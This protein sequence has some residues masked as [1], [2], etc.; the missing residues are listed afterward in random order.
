VRTA[1]AFLTRLPVPAPAEPSLD[2]A[3][4]FFPL[5]GLLVGGIAAGV[6]ALGDQ[7][8][9]PLPSTLLAIAAALL[10]TGALHEDGL[11]DVADGLGAHVSRER[12]LE[13]LRDPRVGTFGSLALLVAVGLVLTTVGAL[14]TEHAARAL[15]AAHVLSRWAMLPVSRFVP[16]ARPGGAGALLRVKTP[17]LIA[18]TV[19]AAVI[20]VAAGAA[21][22]LPAAAIASAASAAALLRGLGGVTGDGY[23]ATAKLTEV[24]VCTTL[25]ALWA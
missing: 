18:A 1:V 6:R 16:P 24:T 8:L 10:V 17:A 19:L 11:A 4:A 14:D 20:A 22:A 5:V 25:A 3:A 7:V 21:A 15:I 2:R 12:R 9:P 13:I 23:G